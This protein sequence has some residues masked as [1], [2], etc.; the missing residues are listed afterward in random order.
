MHACLILLSKSLTGD[1]LELE[2]PLAYMAKHYD[3]DNPSY[4]QALFGSE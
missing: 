1:I 4:E 2:H 3:A